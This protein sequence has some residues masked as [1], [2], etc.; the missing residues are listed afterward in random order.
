MIHTAGRMLLQAN[1]SAAKTA[2]D[3]AADSDKAEAQH[4]A[5]AT[6][7]GLLTQ[8]AAATGWGAD[9]LQVLTLP[10]NLLL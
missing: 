10:L 4:T 5:A 6:T 1:Q 8:A 3:A 9:F 2:A 7:E